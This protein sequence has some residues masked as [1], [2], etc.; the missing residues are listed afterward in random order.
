MR[1]VG[2]AVAGH[3]N[4]MTATA[5][6][7]QRP[8]GV[9]VLVLGPL[10]V[11]AEGRTLHVGGSHRRRLLALLASRAG[12]MAPVDAIVDALWG[13]QPPPSAAKTV[14][15]HVVRLR[16][17]LGGLGASIVETVPGGY[18]LALDA[19]AVDAGQAERLAAEGRELLRAGAPTAAGERFSAALE[20]WRGPAYV[21]FRDA[22]FAASDGVR[23]DELHLAT[24]ENLAEAW[25]ATTSAAT[26]VAALERLVRDEP[27]RERAWGLLMRAL[28]ATGRQH[29]ALGAFQR[30]RQVLAE[31]FGLEPGPDLRAVERQILDQDP[32]LGATTGRAA[33]AA[34]LHSSTPFI[35]RASEVAALD[36]AWRMAQK[37]TGQLRIVSGPIDA[38]RTRLAADLAG[39]TL[40]GGGDVAY[41]R[42]TDG[43]DSLVAASES[44]PSTLPGAIVDAVGERCRRCPMV[45]IVDDVEWAPA[46]VVSMI[47]ALAA[48]VNDLALLLVL[49]VDPAAGGPA[50]ATVGRLDSAEACT[51]RLGPMSD[52]EVAAVVAADGVDDDAVAAVVAIASGRP[53]VARREA[54]AWAE[55]TASE[56]LTAAA[57]SSAGALAVAEHAQ[58]SVLDEVVEL[59]AARARRDELRSTLW[60]GRQ[61]YR[62]LAS[63]GPQDAE[64]F[65]GRERL[66][67][68]LATRV[69]ERRLVAVVGASGSGKSSLVRAGLIPLARSGRLPGETP[70]HAHVMVP[71]RDPLGVLDAIEDLDDAGPRLLVVD[72][73]EEVFTA[74]PVMI[75]AFTTRLLDLAGD[76]ALDV[77]VVVVV[78]ADEYGALDRA[79][80]VERSRGAR[81]APRRTADRR[82]GAPDRRGTGAAHRLDRRAGV[83]GSRRPRCRRLRRRLAARVG[84]HGRSVGTPR[85]R[86]AARRP[87][88]GDRRHRDSRRA[89]RR[90]GGGA[91][92]IRD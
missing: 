30:A 21:E 46:P 69:L 2:D 78:R 79:G 3:A 40:D 90:A 10:A 67:A 20:L 70:W 7:R 77:H 84:G 83:G 4:R 81:P 1:D 37:G 12:R 9:H 31:S 24:Q 41:V 38:G 50:V 11:E 74:Q 75:E 73:F 44:G 72:Q 85:R 76:P 65:V 64:L 35:G 8:S 13:A 53:G 34:A 27:G 61:P 66:V 57:S 17:S 59:V 5:D 42:A 28:Y 55:R 92:G 80:R 49:I 39:R 43:L 88:P 26:A 56:R 86:R 48:A 25:L 22:D 45:L 32:S 47:A 33:L 91:V 6:T 36:S 52:A 14:Q 89:A 51:L 16:R 23:L 54:A 18:L 58:V 19:D 62:S 29:E 68:E 87:L 15:S 71:G 82:R 60:T 63:Y